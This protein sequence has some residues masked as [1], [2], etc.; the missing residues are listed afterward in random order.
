MRVLV[1]IT[2]GFDEAKYMYYLRPGYWESVASAG[3]TPIILPPVNSPEVVNHYLEVCDGFILSGGDDIDP[4]FWGEDPEPGLGEI[5]PLRDRFEIDLVRRIV[6]RNKPALFI[7]RG[8]QVLNVALGGDLIQDL[9]SDMSHRQKAPRYHPFHDILVEKATTLYHLFQQETV[10]VNSF[11]HQAIR[12][13]APGL[14]ATARARDGVVEAVEYPDKG[15]IL[16]VQWH[17]EAMRDEL[18]TRLFQG[19][20]EAAAGR[21]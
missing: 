9:Q 4:A 14:V 17:P 5:D 19:L 15:W 11:H 16:G 10:K 1:G 8:I 3:G 18:S 2:C 7:C 12:N 6:E 13:L 21:R 20:V